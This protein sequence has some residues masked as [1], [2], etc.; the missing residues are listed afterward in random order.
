MRTMLVRLL[1]LLALAACGRVITITLPGGPAAGGGGATAAAV[2]KPPKGY[3]KLFS[4]APHAFRYST[5][6]EPVRAGRVSERYELR[7][8]DCA[9]L[10]AGD[11]GAGGV[12]I[13]EFHQ[14]VG[15][16]VLQDAVFGSGGGF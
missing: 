1:L 8:G 16:R 6:G 15:D 11:A 2:T 7:D 5:A 14:G 4:P 9:G 13:G 12:R 10:L 3:A